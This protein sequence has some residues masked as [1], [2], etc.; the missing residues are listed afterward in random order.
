MR[1]PAHR[2]VA[3]AIALISTF[4]L[5]AAETATQA[6]ILK[7]TGTAAQVQMPGGEARAL[8]VGE[9]LPQGATII[10]GAGTQVY[11]APFDGAV[12]TIQANSTVLLEK[13]AIDSEG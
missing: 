3:A 7:I 8:T 2:L 9:T 12:S 5:H 6:R 13:L 11:V 4:G 1:T 10:T